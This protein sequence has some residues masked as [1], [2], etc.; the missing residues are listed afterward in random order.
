MRRMTA[1]FLCLILLVGVISGCGQEEEGPYIPT[2]DGLTW[3]EVTTPTSGVTEQ[4]MSLAYYPGRSLN[5]YQSSD[6]TNRALFSLLYQNLFV[7][8]ADYTVYPVLC[9][10]YS[11][12]RDMRTYT[13][14]LEEATF[15]DGAALSAADVA[16]SLLAAKS[17][18]YY[19]G[20]FGFVKD[21]SAVDGAVT[22]TLETPY[23]NFPLLLDVP[24]VKKDQVSAARP[25]GTGPYQYEEFEDDGLRL[26][27]RK[28]WWCEALLPVTAER[29]R[30]VKGENAAQLRD[31]F[32]FSDLSLVCTDPGAESYVDFHSDYE[33]WDS[34][35][36]IF[37]YLACN[38]DS[39]VLG[40]KSI[41]AALTYA[42]DRDRIAEE[43]YRGFAYGSVLPASPQSPFYT[44]A[45][46]KDIVFN[47]EKLKQAVTA[48][49]LEDNS[50][51]FLANTDDGVRLRAAR[52]IAQ[53][54]TECGLKV[55]M[56]ELDGEAYRKALAEGKFDL[57]LGQTKLSANMDLSAFF[58]TKGSLNFG[59]MSDPAIYALCLDSLANSGNYYTLYQKILEDG[60]LCPALFRSNAIFTQRGAFSA[61]DPAR[62][63]VF[64][65]TTG[66]TLADA[67][68]VEE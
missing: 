44:T 55:T 52:A 20:R 22:V 13:F 4:I 3:D 66:K 15:S 36:G 59:G 32:E 19:S 21:I 1:L 18:G 53:S 61:L 23:E 43:Y 56:S 17:S 57:Y 50:V 39:P 25:L 34:E 16:A 11:V 42:I 65:Y 64:F 45:L 10:N 27:R 31:E 35:N 9:K 28:D 63:S 14:Y 67:L 62:D 54:L 41:R 6:Q 40:N 46:A 38:S 37:I 26:R 29:I 47:T 68:I 58:A 48:A 51:V 8:G 12:S 5:P 60:M 2:G 49:A 30:L 7:V 24:I 33:L